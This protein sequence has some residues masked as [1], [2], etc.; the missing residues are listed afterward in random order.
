MYLVSLYF[1]N[2]SSNIIKGLINKV[3]DKCG[4]SFMVDNN[5]P[6]HITIA[7]F[8]SNN[9]EK[10]IEILDKEIKSIKT[11]KITWASI[12]SFKSSVLFLAPVLNEYLHNLCTKIYESI[13]D[14]DNIII[15]KYYLPFQWMP[16]TTIAKQLNRDELLI[17]F[18][19]LEKNFNI[20]NGMVTKITLSS[21]NPYRDIVVWEI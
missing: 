20:L 10:V 1:D 11:G 12:G 16:H 15:S 21:T 17:A 5:V 13:K 7:A 14:V 9:E 19:E 6:P 2:K 18:E 8:Q 3:S 4:N